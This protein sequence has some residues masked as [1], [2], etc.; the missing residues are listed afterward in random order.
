[1]TELNNTEMHKRVDEILFYIWDPIG[2]SPNPFARAEYSSYARGVLSIVEQSD[3]IEPISEHLA[4]IIKEYMEII[5]DK[6][7]CD[8]TAELL[9]QNKQAI[10]EGCA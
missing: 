7:R 3:T 5:P 10:I 6:K 1:M 4:R 2:V 9:L 8:Y